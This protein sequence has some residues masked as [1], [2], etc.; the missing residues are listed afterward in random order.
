MITETW[1]VVETE[2]WSDCDT[3]NII[4][5]FVWAARVVYSAMVIVK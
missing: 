2:P 3:N 5:V 4:I 1:S